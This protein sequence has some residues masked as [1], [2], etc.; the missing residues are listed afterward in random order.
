[1]EN[2]N[3][4]EIVVGLYKKD[5]GEDFN[6]DKL[7]IYVVQEKE[8]K[9][10]ATDIKGASFPVEDPGF[11][12]RRRNHINYGSLDSFD[13]ILIEIKNYKLLKNKLT[14]S[15]KRVSKLLQMLE[16]NKANLSAHN[17]NESLEKNKNFLSKRFANSFN[18]L[19]KMG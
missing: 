4:Q 2:V 9:L 8:G 13:L 3:G 11:H 16:D 14:K 18:C 12:D 15:Q 1:M 17:P 7:E 10:I 6:P 19:H 5:T